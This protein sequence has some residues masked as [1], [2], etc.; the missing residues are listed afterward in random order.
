MSTNPFPGPHTE[1][2]AD[3]KKMISVI[4]AIKEVFPRCHVTLFIADIEGKDG[5]PPRFNYASTANRDDMVAVLKAF[6]ER[7]ENEKLKISLV[8]EKRDSK[9]DVKNIVIVH[10]EEGVE[11][12]TCSSKIFDEI[13]SA[14]QRYARKHRS[15]PTIDSDLWRKLAGH[16]ESEK[17]TFSDLAIEMSSYKNYRCLTV[18]V[19]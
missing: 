1:L 19:D 15:N 2:P 12:Y 6:I 17:Y 3:K 14:S 16:P 8:D 13:Q 10:Y 5:L 11:Y 7:Q 18:G 9:D 4:E